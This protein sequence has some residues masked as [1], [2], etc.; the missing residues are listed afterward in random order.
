MFLLHTQKGNYVRWWVTMWGVL[1]SLIVG[2]IT[3]GILISKYH[4]VHLKYIQFLRCQPYLNEAKKIIKKELL[5]KILCTDVVFWTHP[6]I[7]ESKFA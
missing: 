6:T 4:I 2:V 1:I 5:G 7:T 3:Q